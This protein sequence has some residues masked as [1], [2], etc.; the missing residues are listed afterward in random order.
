MEST[1]QCF[2][3]LESTK[4]FSVASEK[5]LWS[6]IMS[7]STKSSAKANAKTTF[8]A[9]VAIKMEDS[10]TLQINSDSIDGQLLKVNTTVESLLAKRKA[11]R[12]SSTPVTAS[13]P[14]PCTSNAQQS[15]AKHSFLEARMKQLKESTLRYKTLLPETK[16]QVIYNRYPYF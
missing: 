5:Y 15:T 11:E 2:F 16:Q 6:A 3:P 9:V 1:D 7:T 4:L 12:I 14:A 10:P 8:P 13:T